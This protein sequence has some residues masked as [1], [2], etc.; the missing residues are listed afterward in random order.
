MIEVIEVIVI[1]S[2]PKSCFAVVVVSIDLF[3]E[4]VG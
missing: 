1:E 3:L 4:A 2:L